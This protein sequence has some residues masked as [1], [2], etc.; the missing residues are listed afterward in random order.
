MAVDKNSAFSKP[1]LVSPRANFL[2]SQE[3][4]AAAEFGYVKREHAFAPNASYA[5]TPPAGASPDNRFDSAVRRFLV[6]PAVSD[7]ALDGCPW[8]VKRI[9]FMT[10]LICAV[11]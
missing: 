2:E 7:R 5:E 11:A 4:I 6:V 10:G 1:P 9:N 8:F 3:S